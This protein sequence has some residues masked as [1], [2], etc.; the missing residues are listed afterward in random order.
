MSTVQNKPIELY[1]WTTPNGWKISVLLE[2]LGVPYNV[3]MINIG[4]GDQFKDEFLEIS[5]NN[6]IPAIVDSEG[7]GG[8]PISVFESAA[9]MKY[10]AK[11]FDKFYPS[12]ERAQVKV[13]EWLFWQMGGFGPMLGQNHHFNKY[14]PEKLPYAMKRYTDETHRLYGVLNKRLA[15]H[16][17]V[18]GEYSIADM[19]IY[20]WATLWEGQGM[21]IAEFPHVKAWLDR[22]GAREAVQKGMEVGKEEREKLNL[23]TDK[24]AQKVL[25]NQRSK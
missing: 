23:A 25:F 5:P 22:L 7:P 10:L 20:G 21:D 11:K 2:E 19:A 17:Y 8:E 13:D 14:A 1:Y 12:D 24:D 4:A 18:A 16:D 15:D 6:K 3:H 9:I